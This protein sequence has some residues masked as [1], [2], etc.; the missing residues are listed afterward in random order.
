MFFESIISGKNKLSWVI[1]HA[2]LGLVATITPFALLFWFY[3]TLITSLNKAINE[4]IKGNSFF[5]IAL[6]SYLTSFEILG[7][8]AQTYPFIPSELSKYLLPLASIIGVLFSQKK[9]NNLWLILGVLMTIGLL[10]DYSGERNFFDIVNNYF[11]ILAIFFGLFFLSKQKLSPESINVIFKLI[12]FAALSSLAYCFIKTPNYEDI[13]F[14]LNAN[15]ET[16]GGAATNQV[17]TLFGLGLFLTFYFWYKQIPFSGNRIVDISIGL[18]FL[19]QG[20]LLF[21]EGE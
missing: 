20:L 2:L 6:I 9:S 16:S 21:L 5:Y 13:Q 3:L 12:L 19:A 18:A 17:S 7:R 14:N 8:M 11:G 15:F 4:L 10:F 1:F